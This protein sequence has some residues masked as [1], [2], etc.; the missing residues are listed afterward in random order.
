[1]SHGLLTE[2]QFKVLVC[3]GRGLTQSETAREL[4]TTRANVS[5]I[6]HRARKRI[7]LARETITAYHSTLTDHSV[8]IPKGVRSYDVPSIVLREADKYG[9]HLQSNIVEIIRLVRGLRPPVLTT[10]RTTRAISLV[11]NQRGKLRAVT[12]S[13]GT[14]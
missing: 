2:L 13:S 8:R 14:R 4:R 11:F 12:A 1:M 10:G 6:E 3:R 7:E 5:M 9:I